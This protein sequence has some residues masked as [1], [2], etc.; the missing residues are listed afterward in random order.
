MTHIFR[1][2]TLFLVFFTSSFAQKKS[3]TLEEVWKGTFAP[4]YL[5]SLN[6]MNNGSQYTILNRDYKAKTSSVDVYEYKSASKVETLLDSKDLEAI[7][8]FENYEFSADEQKLLL[9]TAYQKIYRHSHKGIYYVYDR[10]TK[11]LN[12]ISDQL[13][14]EPTFSPKGDKIAFVYDNNL[15]IKDLKTNKE[16]Q[17]TTDGK[18]NKIINGITDWVYEE[19]FGFVRA[20][21]WNSTGTHLAYIRFDEHQVPEFSM[22]VYGSNL[23]PY[24]DVFKYPKAGEKNAEV[25]LFTYEI[26]SQKTSEVAL[27]TY[28]NFYIPRIQ[29]TKKSNILSAQILNRHQNELDLL[30]VDTSSNNTVTKVLE[31][32]DAAYIEITDSLT[33]LDD[34]SF[35][36]TSEKDGHNHIYHYNASGK[37]INQVTSGPWEVTDYYGYDAKTKT[38]FYQ[39]VEN[40]TINRDIYAIKI[41]GKGKKRLSTETGTH[42]ADFSADFSLFI[43]GFS[44]TSTPS[45]HTLH[46]AKNGKVIRQIKNSKSLLQK[47]KGYKPLQDK[48]FSTININ[49][50]TLNMWIIK[51]ANFDPTK[52]YPLLMYQYSGPGSQ[53]VRNSWH[54]MNDFWYQILADQG[55]VIACVDGRGTG[56]KGAKFKK[57]TQNNLGKY[58]VDDQ[59]AAAQLLG[60][61]PYIDANRIG[62]WGWSYG[63]FM[64]SNCLFKAPDTFKMAIAVAP[65]TSWRFY[66][67]IY[68]ERYLKTPQENPD[69]YDKNSPINYVDHLKG[70]FLLIHGSADDNVHVQ[71]TMQMVEALIQANKQFDWAIYPDRNHGIYGGNTR[72]HLFNKMTNFIKENL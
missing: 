23:Y 26:A 42:N 62:I 40:G 19:E 25:R 54:N 70:K 64:S 59:V 30:F 4:S 2:T 58:E 31:E 5:S 51:P 9:T 6:S 69:G 50:E 7:P 11:E 68:T 55:Y 65:V 38:I 49:G 24:Q 16:Q 29:W 56:M 52:T 43:D 28:N 17:I 33:F 13:I 39:S 35:V 41:N 37:L 53:M 71:N 1:L 8:Y 48:E 10:I 20:F 22:D 18:K 32:K 34:H 46:N 15:Y 60:K 63:G 44:N 57:I 72:L 45:M 66:D 14:Q 21:D 27:S 3:L 36:W 61:R 12:K 47:L 67:T